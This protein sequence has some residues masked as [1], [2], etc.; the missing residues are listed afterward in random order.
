MRSNYSSASTDTVTFSKGASVV[1][2][3]VDHGTSGSAL[4]IANLIAP[5]V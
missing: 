1:V 3:E 2:V 4:T 5:K